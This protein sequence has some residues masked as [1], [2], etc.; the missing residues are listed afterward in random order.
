MQ[1]I[2]VPESKGAIVVLPGNNSSERIVRFSVPADK[3][4][5]QLAIYDLSGRVVQLFCLEGLS[6]GVDYYQP[7]TVPGNRGIYIVRLSAEGVSL[8]AKLL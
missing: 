4:T 6:S 8:S 3:R 5:A 7:V 1:Q 2:V